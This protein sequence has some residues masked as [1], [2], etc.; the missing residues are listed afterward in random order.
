MRKNNDNVNEENEEDVEE[1]NEEVE[2]VKEEVEEKPNNLRNTAKRNRRR[3]LKT[4]RKP[5]TK[6]VA[7]K[8][9][10]TILQTTDFE[11]TENEKRTEITKKIEEIIKLFRDKLIL[12]EKAN[13]LDSIY[14]ETFEKSDKLNLNVVKSLSLVQGLTSKKA[15]KS[16]GLNDKLLIKSD[17]FSSKVKLS[18]DIDKTITSLE[19]RIEKIIVKIEKILYTENDSIAIP[20]QMFFAKKLTK[21]LLQIVNNEIKELSETDRL[22]LYAE[23]RDIYNLRDKIRNINEELSKAEL[24][25]DDN[26]VKQQKAKE[27]ISSDKVKAVPTLL[28][29]TKDKLQELKENQITLDKIVIN[30]YSEKI[31]KIRDITQYL[32]TKYDNPFILQ[33]RLKHLTTMPF[34]LGLNNT[35]NNNNL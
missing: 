16:A 31:T 19:E 23:M 2:G 32:S 11:I 29:K 1:E 22:K 30:K 24:E 33:S 9:I 17:L 25:L 34:F 3:G 27:M 26:L 10:N 8:N 14:R 21:Y 4:K 28:Q 12:D 7:V 6:S 18:K 5:K 35:T 15:L 13:L 20:V